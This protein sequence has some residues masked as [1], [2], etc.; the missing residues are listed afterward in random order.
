MRRP[1]SPFAATPARADWRDI[2]TVPDKDLAAAAGE[3]IPDLIAV[4]VRRG[5]VWY[6]TV[7][8]GWLQLKP[9]YWAARLQPSLDEEIWVSH[10]GAALQ[11]VMPQVNNPP[12]PLTE[13]RR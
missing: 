3:V 1:P 9:G 5:G 13:E 11:P 12:G 8:T 4:W 7:L 10:K 2:T 6:G